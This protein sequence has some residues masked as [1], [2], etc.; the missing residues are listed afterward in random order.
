VSLSLLCRWM[1]RSPSSLSARRPNARSRRPLRLEQLETREVP[2]ATI[3]TVA[4]GGG[5]ADGVAAIRSYVGQ[6]SAVTTDA[7][8]ELFIIDDY[9]NEVREVT[10][11]GIIHDFAGN[12]NNIESD[13]TGI[14]AV[15]AYLTFGDPFNSGGGVAVDSQG[16]VYIADPDAALVYKVTPDGII[17]P[18]AGEGQ[19][20]SNNGDGGPAL[21]GALVNPFAV[22][23]DSKGDVFI[24]DSG[25]NTIRE[26]TPD[27]IIHTVAGIVSGS[28]GAPG[29]FSGDGG[30]ATQADLNSP[31]DVA[32][33]NK[34]DLFIVDSGNNRVR[35]VTADGII[36]TVTG[37]GVAGY[38]GN[39]GPAT[40]AELN[41]NDQGGVSVD[42]AGNLFIA[43][44][45]NNVIREVSTLGIIT[46]VAGTGKPGDGGSG[47]LPT[48]TALNNPT[49]VTVSLSG[50]LYISDSNNNR[51]REVSGVAAPVTLQL[52]TVINSSTQVTVGFNA[53]PGATNYV[54]SMA[55][56]SAASMT[57]PAS[58][59]SVVSSNAQPS[60]NVVSGL[61]PDTIYLFRVVAALSS[62]KTMTA[63]L[64]VETAEPQQGS[65]QVTAAQLRNLAAEVSSYNLPSVATLTTYATALNTYLS[66]YSINAPARLAAF[67][68]SAAAE[69]NGFRT[70]TASTGG[71]FRG[72]G[73][74]MISGQ[75]NYSQISQD[76]FGD[77]RLITTPSM[78]SQ[79]TIAAQVSAFYWGKYIANGQSNTLADQLSLSAFGQ[80]TAD[81][82][83]PGTLAARELYYQHALQ[84]IYFGMQPGETLNAVS[85]AAAST[86]S[87]LL[88]DL[89]GP[90]DSLGKT[91]TLT[92]TRSGYKFNRVVVV[93][94]VLAGGNS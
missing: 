28:L 52:T 40:S 68:A 32:V 85:G 15:K 88:A 61:Q 13:N 71:T 16:D 50:K 83:G 26:V 93:G 63:Y 31:S 24:C 42:G 37:D 65:I 44:S 11:N 60:G 30:P 51:V 9:G 45:G 41:L 46:T 10:P 29:G 33:D 39:H 75:T 91:V 94:D 7:K 4:G 56:S 72:R 66:Q 64:Q 17:N 36:H 70:L 69:T 1:K 53:F 34:G 73:F 38:T 6:P 90:S 22:A 74:L 20:L 48:S 57:V 81:I 59:F 19:S 43:V 86:L 80:I 76:L 18:F 54:L 49:G 82:G 84:N 62:G 79:P 92:I 89:Q 58:K 55:Q 67:L 35:E 27:G 3:T 78:L 12:A 87:T 25:S 77:Q 14:Q 2:S 47:G 21:Q 23:C 5:G 8:G